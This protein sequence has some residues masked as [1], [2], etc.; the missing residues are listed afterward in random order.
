MGLQTTSIAKLGLCTFV[1]VALLSGC[2]DAP[3]R[4]ATPGIDARHA[5]EQ[6]FTLYDWDTDGQLNSEELKVSPPLLDAAAAYDT[7]RDGLLSR[8]ELVAGI[9]SWKRRG[10]GA[11][12]LPFTVR[13]DGRPLQGAEVKLT[14]APFLDGAIASASGTADEMGSGSLQITGDRPTNVPANL[15]VIQPGLYLVEITHPTIPV[16]EVYNKASTLGVEAGI[17]GQNPSG[18]VW[19]LSSKKK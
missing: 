10:I 8:E 6:A 5:A 7:N 15:P 14:P 2:S 17:A 1:T 16:P 11:M 9:E 3:G 4:I 13:L 12:A 18:V 19:E